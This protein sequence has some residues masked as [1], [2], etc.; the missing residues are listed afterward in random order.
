MSCG[1][2]SIVSNIPPNKNLVKDNGFMF[3]LNNYE[4]SVLKM[5]NE[6]NETLNNKRYYHQKSLDSFEFINKNLINS[7]CYQKMKTILDNL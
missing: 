3:D 2:P 4:E 7:Q 6:I 1:I 5:I